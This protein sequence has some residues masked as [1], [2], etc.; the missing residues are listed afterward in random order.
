[1]YLGHVLATRRTTKKDWGT[2]AK[3]STGEDGGRK[4]WRSLFGAKVRSVWRQVALPDFPPDKLGVC[5]H[6]LRELSGENESGQIGID[7][8][9]GCLQYTC[10][11]SST[12]EEPNLEL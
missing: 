7:G 6:F 10:S 1:M 5:F 4:A 2:P 8:R 12:A 9:Y 11:N 3:K